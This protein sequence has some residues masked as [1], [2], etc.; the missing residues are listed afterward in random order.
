MDS[1]LNIVKRNKTNGERKRNLWSK[2]TDIYLGNPITWKPKVKTFDHKT[3]TTKEEKY[4]IPATLFFTKHLNWKQRLNWVVWCCNNGL[5]A[6]YIL[7]WAD[8]NNTC[9]DNNSRR[10]IVNLIEKCTN[11]EKFK[12]TQWAWNIH[13]LS[14]TNLNGENV[15]KAVSRNH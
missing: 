2:I 5:P 6:K 14:F 11:D 7:K 15:F 10:D 1:K 8:L 9:R 13:T 12:K 3:G 4:S